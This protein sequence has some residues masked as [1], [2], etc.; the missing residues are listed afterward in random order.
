MHAKESEATR[1]LTRSSTR[2]IR[3]RNATAIPT[4]L[5]NGHLHHA[6]VNVIALALARGPG[7]LITTGRAI[8]V[9][10]DCAIAPTTHAPPR[11]S[12]TTLSRR[13]TFLRLCRQ[14][15]WQTWT[16][17]VAIAT[18]EVVTAEEGTSVAA[19]VSFRLL[20]VRR[21]TWLTR[22]CR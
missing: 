20:S 5:P 6:V 17:A 18:V 21:C 10:A 16:L 12:R 3:L 7:I 4:T 15:Q 8:R 9:P 11:N 14:F 1:A 13:G 2:G 22:P 19:M